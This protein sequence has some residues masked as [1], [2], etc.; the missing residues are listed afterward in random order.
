M[1]D[2]GKPQS[3]ATSSWRNA[4]T[5]SVAADGVDYAYREL[6]PKAGVPVI[7]LVHLAGTLDNWDPRVVDGIAAKHRVIAF[8]NRGV[9]AS[10]G[11]TPDTIQAMAKDTV[12]FIRALGFDQVDLHGFS[13]G[14]MI[15]QVIAED[16]PEMVR[17]LILTGT[18]PAGGKGIKEVVWVAQLDTLR[19]LLSRQDPKQFL[20]FTR[21]ANGKR[22]GKEFLARLQERTADRDTPITIKSYFAQLK[23]CRRWGKE[24]PH[25]LSLVHQPVL[26]ANGDNDRMLPTPNTLDMARRLPNNEL[27]IYPD[28]GHAGIFQ[29]HEQ[30]V[31]KALEFLGK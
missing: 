22:A 30:F 31:E 25:D 1:N 3:G 10:T 28:A 9:G 4:P 13:M 7:F 17:K 5:R 16:E 21:T 15:A 8:D 2:N 20:F 19:G 11:K 29:F 18:G 24:E 14:G 6:G 26:L 12:T 27:V 23:A